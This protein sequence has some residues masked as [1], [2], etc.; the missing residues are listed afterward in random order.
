V[1]TGFRVH[2]GGAQAVFGVRADIATYGKVLGGG[3]PIG[4]VAGSARFLDA[5]DGG[6]WRFGD[7]SAPQVGVT[8]FAGTFV[9][10][11]LALAA[12]RA[13]LQRL[14]GDGQALQRELNLRTTRFVESLHN[15][16]R[17]LGAPLQIA[18]FSSWFCLRLPPELPLAS[19]FYAALRMR[20]IHAWEGRPCFLTTAHSDDDLQQIVQAVRDALAEMQQA[21]FLPAGPAGPAAK[22]ARPAGTDVPAVAGARRGRGP[23]GREAWFVPDPARPGKYLQII[24]GMVRHD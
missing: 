18:H 24:D 5:L 6:S 20:G 16:A 1:V 15:A 23:D 13:V 3:L 4:V 21:G 2:P 17:E 22:P 12:A 8:F 11:P 14:K 10:H 9:R 19:L 7:D